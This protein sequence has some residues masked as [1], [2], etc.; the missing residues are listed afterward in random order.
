MKDFDLALRRAYFAALSN[1]IVIEGNPIPIADSKLEEFKTENS[2]YILVWSQNGRAEDTKCSYRSYSEIILG[3]VH[4][5]KGA[6]TKKIVDLVADQIT[7][8]LFPTRKTTTLQ[9]ESGFR[10]YVPKLISTDTSG[11]SQVENSND[12][13]IVKTLV[14]SNIIIQ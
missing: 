7:Q 9:I 13:R 4:T 6:G 5:M 3:I 8:R 12:Y 2:I 10:L 14:F 11:I 1:Q